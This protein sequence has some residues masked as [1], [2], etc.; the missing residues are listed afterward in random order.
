[1]YDNRL[2]PYVTRVFTYG[3][4][5]EYPLLAEGLEGTRPGIRYR[6]CDIDR[7]HFENEIVVVVTWELV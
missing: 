6:V 4:G 1:M 7:T 2:E 5:C 3:P